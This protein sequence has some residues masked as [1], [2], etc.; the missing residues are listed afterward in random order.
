MNWLALS[1]FSLKGGEAMNL[2][3]LCKAK[4]KTLSAVSAKTKIGIPYLSNLSTRKKKNPSI[5]I[6][7]KLANE[8]GVKIEEIQKTLKEVD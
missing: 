3:E 8:L 7:S 4:G 6:V 1:L 5:E 2:K